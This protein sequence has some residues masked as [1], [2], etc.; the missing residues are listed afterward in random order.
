M[1]SIRVEVETLTA[2]FLHVE[3][4][5]EARWRAAPFRGLARWWFRALV[6]T[7]VPPDEV[8]RREAQVFGTAEDPSAVMLRVFPDVSSS[9]GGSK[10]DVNPGSKK[11]AM[12]YAIPPKR[13]AVLEIVPTDG[14]DGG[15]IRA[16][17]AYV[18]LW[19][20]LHLGGVGQRSRRGAGS[21]RITGVHGIDAPKPVRASEP[22]GYKLEIEQGLL[23]VRRILGV[24]KFRSLGPEA[25]FPV[26]HKDCA[27]TWV[28]RLSLEDGGGS[29]PTSTE[30]R[31]RLAIMNARR[32]LVSHRSGKPEWE[33]GGVSLPSR[34]SSPTWVRVAAITQGSA[35]LVV[36][37][38]KHR[39]GGA[40]ADW[41]NVENFVRAMDSNA[42]PVD[43]GG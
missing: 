5:G 28:V 40:G 15:Q 19:A 1:D 25:E 16:R 3:P 4:D 32:A 36:T 37:L 34:L 29:A 39:G 30:E 13:K 22:T 42:L 18:A 23:E 6:G 17:H 35:L 38:L 10:F 14:R 24:L 11:S 41:R 20:A 12:R 43:L 2:T 31:V 21:L 27:R 26:L 33:F 8:R 9:T 7:S